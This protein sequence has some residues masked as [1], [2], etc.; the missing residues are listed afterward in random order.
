MPSALAQAALFQH[1]ARGR[2]DVQHILKAVSD[3]TVRTAR[4]TGAPARLVADVQRF[5]ARLVEPIERDGVRGGVVISC[6]G[7]FACLACAKDVDVGGLIGNADLDDGDHRSRTT[8]VD[9]V[10]PMWG[11]LLVPP[12]VYPSIVAG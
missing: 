9:P 8:D 11:F 7:D 1:R 12:L 3:L 2:E 5:V 6:R 10:A 4:T